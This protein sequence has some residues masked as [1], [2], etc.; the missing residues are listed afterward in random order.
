MRTVE[1]GDQ[2]SILSEK[3]QIYFY[4]NCDQSFKIDRFMLCYYNVVWECAGEAQIV[5]WNTWWLQKC[6]ANLK[7]DRMVEKSE[8]ILLKYIYHWQGVQGIYILHTV[9]PRSSLH[10]CGPTSLAVNFAVGLQ[11]MT[12]LNTVSTAHLWPG[13]TG[14]GGLVTTNDLMYQIPAWESQ[15]CF[16]FVKY[17]I[18]NYW[19]TESTWELRLRYKKN[20]TIH[21]L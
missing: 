21:Y 19:T 13:P 16:M 4:Q 9:W 20:R 5:I 10:Q 7:Y 2:L 6:I 12:G 18:T 15:H 8:S 3:W 11:K 17:T 14:W 1:I